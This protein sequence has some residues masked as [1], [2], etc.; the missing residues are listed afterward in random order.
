MYVYT[1]HPKLGGVSGVC[2]IPV[3]KR[4]LL[5]PLSSHQLLYPVSKRVS[6]T[7]AA[8]RAHWL[9]LSG[10]HCP[11]DP[12]NTEEV[13]GSQG[14]CRNSTAHGL[15]HSEYSRGRQNILHASK[16]QKLP[17]I[18]PS[19]SPTQMGFWNISQFEGKWEGEGEGLRAYLKT[20][21]RKNH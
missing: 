12:R 1:H 13:Q 3:S 19:L 9:C 15:K 7:E 17:G 5:F 16:D 14:S 10:L 8:V 2:T 21:S 11:G 4:L 18:S 6:N 20:T